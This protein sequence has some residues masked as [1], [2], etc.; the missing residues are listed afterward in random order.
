MIGGSTG[1]AL[2]NCSELASSLSF[3]S[4]AISIASSSKSDLNLATEA[5]RRNAINDKT[6]NAPYTSRTSAIIWHLASPPARPIGKTIGI[7]S[8]KDAEVIVPIYLRCSADAKRAARKP[9]SSPADLQRDARPRRHC[10]ELSWIGGHAARSGP[11]V[12]QRDGCITMA[13]RINVVNYGADSSQKKGG[14][15]SR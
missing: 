12:L 4:A 1:R 9:P 8:N 7:L 6:L 11:K 2:P 15:S 10:G 13:L 5:K 14:R 3:S